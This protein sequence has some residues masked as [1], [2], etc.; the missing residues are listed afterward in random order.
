M[1]R[2]IQ[3]GLLIFVILISFIFYKSYFVD[4]KNSESINLSQSK[5]STL[6]NQNNLIKNLYLIFNS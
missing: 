6:E 1:K 3:L 4:D 2:L 5:N